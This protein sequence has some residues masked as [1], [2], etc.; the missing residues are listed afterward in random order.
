[1]V[2]IFAEASQ[3]RAGRKA[4]THWLRPFVEHRE[5]GTAA[6]SVGTPENHP[7]DTSCRTWIFP[8]SGW[9]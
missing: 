5:A 6:A 1:M 2:R 4:V 8:P 7:V 9:G 3:T